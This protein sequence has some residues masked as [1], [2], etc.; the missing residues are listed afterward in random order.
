MAG[1]SE[2]LEQVLS[3]EGGEEQERYLRE[4]RHLLSLEAVELLKAR[5]D[6][7]LRDD[8]ASALSISATALAVAEILDDPRA[9]ALS[10][11]ARAQA[12]HQTGDLD[13][14]LQA[15]DRSQDL[16]QGL[17]DEVEEARTLLGKIDALAQGSRYDEAL[18]LADRCYGVFQAHEQPLNCGKVDLNRGNIYHRLDRHPEALQCYL[19]AR[20]AFA[21]AGDALLCAMADMN[22]GN[23][24]T[25]LNQFRQASQ[26]FRRAS[27][28]YQEANLTALAAMNESNEGYLHY[29]EGD[30]TA[31]LSLFSSARERLAALGVDRNLATVDLDAGEL[32]CALNLLDEASECYQRAAKAFQELGIHS[33]AARALTGLAVVAARRGEAPR[34]LGYLQEAAATFAAEGNQLWAAIVDLHR[35]VL[36]FDAGN[37]T[38]AL[39]RCCL[40]RESLAR[41]ALPGKAAH[42]QLVEGRLRERTGDHRGAAACFRAA[43]RVGR[44]LRSHW[45][46]YEGYYGLAR[47]TAADWPETKERYL[48]RAIASLE[49]QRAALIPEELKIAFVGD[50]LQP[51]ADLV[52]LLLERGDEDSTR[53]AFE[54][55]ERAKSQALVDLL[56]GKVEAPRQGAVPA[57]VAVRMARLRAELN[58]LYS[59]VD[60]HERSGGQRAHLVAEGLHRD[61]RVREQ[62][63][64]RL[65]RRVELAT[66]EFASLGQAAFASLPAV[67][68]ALPPEGTLLEYFIA[69]GEVGAFLVQSGG[70]KV[71]PAL[72]SYEA[73]SHALDRLG[74][75]LRRPTYPAPEVD[76]FAS[77]RLECS[78]LHLSELHRLLLE[79]LQ[80]ELTRRVVVVPTGLLYYVPFHALWDGAHYLVEGH[81]VSYAPSASV[82]AFC[83][84]KGQERWERALVLAPDDAQLPHIR[85]EAEAVARLFP[86]AESA[87][88][89]RA[90]TALFKASAPLTDVIHIASHGVFRGDNPLFS[91]IKLGD[92]WLSVGDVYGLNLQSSLVTL[93]ACDTGV[94][95]VAPGDELLGLARGFIY[96]GT[97]SL[98]V[99]LW[100]VND[101]ATADLMELFYKRLRAGATRGAALREAQLHTMAHR[102]HPYYWAPFVLVGRAW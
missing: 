24:Y 28:A 56:S 23:S 82:L 52:V 77:H 27:Q 17:G 76:A 39:D 62:A 44:Q 50:K 33:D 26:S 64:A 61:V 32:Y 78:R 91:T 42:G 75:Q 48:R 1:A 8:I 59:A 34:A 92:G 2:L 21:T 5:A 66:P 35:A 69:R 6:H 14:A 18:A 10:A 74:F 49:R 22:L 94:N 9:R 65:Q 100:T 67:Q 71:F 72:A 37:F 46:L 86:Q 73:V 11:R 55:A 47:V 20:Q 29:V 43:V 36:E 60:R 13:G 12:L 98:L 80:A 4:H 31:A 88:G 38:Q 54:V 16:Y 45:L 15:Y 85:R 89:P 79:P 25:N 30:F 93:S 40:A 70:I 63:L 53:Q 68:H 57:E 58:S 101:E 84:G 83:L 87:V 102:P 19:R 7:A 81:E 90:T 97:P 41:Q 51:Y 99:S 95:H 3:L 96:A